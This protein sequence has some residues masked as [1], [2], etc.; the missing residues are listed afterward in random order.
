MGAERYSFVGLQLVKD[1]LRS[2]FS[3][4]NRNKA[5][6]DFDRP[7]GDL[8]GAAP[9]MAALIVGSFKALRNALLSSSGE[10]NIRCK[11]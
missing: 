10:S 1:G 7:S 6:S 2:E 8:V 4:E 11:I 9:S 5:N 3:S